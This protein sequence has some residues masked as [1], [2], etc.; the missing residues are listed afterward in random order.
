MIAV[1]RATCGIRASGVFKMPDAHLQ[2][3]HLKIVRG[4]ASS[5]MRNV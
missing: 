2:A 3:G 5:V 1:R 4:E